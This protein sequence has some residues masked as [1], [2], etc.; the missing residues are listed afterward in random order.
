MS[1]PLPLTFAVKLREALLPHQCSGRGAISWFDDHCRL[2]QSAGPK[3]EQVS[4]RRALKSVARQFGL[5]GKSRHSKK[6]VE[7]SKRLEKRACLKG[8][9]RPFQMSSS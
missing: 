3:T 2:L 7:I 6:G 1:W 4:Q 9:N 8:A 5:G